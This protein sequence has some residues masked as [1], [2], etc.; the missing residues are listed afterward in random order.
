MGVGTDYDNLKK[1]VSMKV[2]NYSGW[3]GNNLD[4]SVMESLLM[5]TTPK[6]HWHSCL[7]IIDN[8][9]CVVN[10]GP[11]SVFPSL[12]SNILSHTANC[13]SEKS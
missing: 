2:L 11:E 3:A 12:L 5:P 10:V 8:I 1:T 9:Q 13:L 7:S 6:L 4:D